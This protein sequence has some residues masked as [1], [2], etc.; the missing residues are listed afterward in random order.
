VIFGLWAA[1]LFGAVALVLFAPLAIRDG[2]FDATQVTALLPGIVGLFTPALSVLAG[3]WF[4]RE[5]IKRA[6]AVKVASDRCVV[7]VALTCMYLVIVVMLIAWPLFVVEYP[8]TLQLVEGGSLEDRMN[9]ATK[10]AA[11]LSP[12]ALAPIHYLT[13]R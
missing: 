7:A 8:D 13:S 10:V 5:E 1:S 2:T 12:L 6:R 11:M 3:F 9:Q 4:P